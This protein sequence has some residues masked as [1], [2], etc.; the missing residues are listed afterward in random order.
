VV[1]EVD[2]PAFRT[3][4]LV[5]PDARVLSQKTHLVVYSPSAATV[6]R[7]A[8]LADIRGREDPGDIIYA[9]EIAWALREYG[10][11]LPPLQRRPRVIDDVVFSDYPYRALPRWGQIEPAQLI[12]VLDCFGARLADV[13]GRHALRRLDVAAYAQQRLLTAERHD[14]HERG[15]ICRLRTLLSFW[16]DRHS[17][18]AISSRD[19]ALVH[20]DLHAGNVV[21]ERGDLKLLDLD[22]AAV[23]PRLYDLAAWY[24]R[25]RL[26]DPAPITAAVELARCQSYWRE[27]DFTALIGWKLLSS[28]THLARYGSP[29]QMAQ[30]L[31]ALV[32]VAEYEELQG[33][34]SVV[35]A[36]Q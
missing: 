13:G 16:S 11:V 14:V 9:H 10:P 20:G 23:G 17:F 27:D 28:M 25:H 30:A 33:S 2:L 34:W 35:V 4:G 15:L 24:V 6:T 3:A 21:A 22:S 7:V 36:H 8:S 12:A 31:P 29:A 18:A 5:A 1:S 32:V 26:G 19:P